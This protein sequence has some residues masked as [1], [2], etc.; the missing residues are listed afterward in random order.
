VAERCQSR[1]CRLCLIDTSRA[2]IVWL[3]HIKRGVGEDDFS[4][5]LE[6]PQRC[7]AYITIIGTYRQ[8]FTCASHRVGRWSGELSTGQARSALC[9][10]KEAPSPATRIAMRFDKGAVK[11]FDGLH[12]V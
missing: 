2:P 11:R 5:Y 9:Q 8:L 1:W 4:Q 10:L 7:T 12:V 6:V 3:V